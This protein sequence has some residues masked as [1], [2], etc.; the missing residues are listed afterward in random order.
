M[1]GAND[2]KGMLTRA[3]H[4]EVFIGGMAGGA[5]C[6]KA[7]LASNLLL[8]LRCEISDETWEGANIVLLLT[9]PDRR[10]YLKAWLWA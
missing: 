3:T 5:V 8:F 1:H 10:L 2:S 6:A 4:R 9:P 7:T